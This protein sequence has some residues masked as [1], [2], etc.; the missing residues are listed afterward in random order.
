MSPRIPLGTDRLSELQALVQVAE[1][2][3]LSAAARQLGVSP[4]AVS[5][6]M[7][8][9]ETRLGVQLLHRSTRKVQLKP[10]GWR[11]Y[12]Q[13][14]RVMA[15]LDEL[16]RSVATAAE[17]RGTVRITASTSTGHMLL[18]PLVPRLLA[19]YPGLSLDLRLTDEVVDL[20]DAGID[21]AVRWGR[22][23]ASDLIARRL[24]QTRQAIVAAPAYLAAHG[25]RS[26]RTNYKPTSASAGTTAAPSRPGRFRSMAGGSKSTLATWCA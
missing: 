5:K 2:G 13:G 1:R 6:L 8:R 9:L 16:E 17:P 20:A 12:E 25:C 10:E 24:G 15:D 14:Q 19:E 4:S 21:I 26:N 23:P 22:L 11:L 7:T 3:N 18:V